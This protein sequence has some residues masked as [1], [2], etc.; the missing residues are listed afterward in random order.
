MHRRATGSKALRSGKVV[1]TTQCRASALADP[2]QTVPA[3]EAHGAGTR[4]MIIG[5]ALAEAGCMFALDE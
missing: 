1:S 5:E 4:V 3:G 2:P